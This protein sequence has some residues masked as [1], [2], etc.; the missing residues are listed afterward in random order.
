ML[1]EAIKAYRCEELRELMRKEGDDFELV[2]IRRAA[3]FCEGFIPGAVFLGLGDRF[4]EWASALLH[5][6]RQIILVASEGELEPGVALLSEAGLTNIAGYVK[7]GL[8][9][10]KESGESLDMI[11]NVDAGEMAMD[12][13]FDKNLMVLDVRHRWEFAE[14]HVQGAVNIPLAEMKD[15]LNI[16]QFDERDNLYLHSAYGYRSVIAASLLKIQGYHNLRN[17]TGGWD[18]IRHTRGIR[19]EKE[20]A[21]LN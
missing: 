13:P 10:W 5:P 6:R 14:G 7:G 3:D 21:S 2:D 11:V 1:N 18:S 20:S 9:A 17:V 19:I 15:P 8:E 16:A 12:I 4:K